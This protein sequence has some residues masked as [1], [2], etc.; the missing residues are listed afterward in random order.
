LFEIALEATNK[1]GEKMYPAKIK[2][3]RMFDFIKFVRHS[4]TFIVKSQLQKVVSDI[5]KYNKK[6]E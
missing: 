3:L 4:L 6:K 5:E 2:F 1:K